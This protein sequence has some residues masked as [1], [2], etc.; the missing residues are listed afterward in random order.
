[1]FYVLL[2]L[3]VFACL[4]GLY[5]IYK[6]IWYAVKMLVLRMKLKKCKSDGLSVEFKRPFYKTVFGK[7]GET[8]FIVSNKRERYAVSVISFVSTHGR[9]NFERAQD[10][11]YIEARRYN[12]IFY[13]LYVN[14]GTEP[15]HSKDY[16]RETRFSRNRL[17]VSPEEASGDK[18]VLLIHPRPKLLT[19]T[20]TRFRYL[21][22]GDSIFGY[23]IMYASDF[24]EALK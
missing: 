17:Y 2:A 18:R 21:G 11:T 8:D 20:D 14:T 13:N 4:L 9:W 24:F 19:Y 16:R 23:Q 7:K 22:A 15:E 6:V 3:A 10:D 12:R 1:M 5:A